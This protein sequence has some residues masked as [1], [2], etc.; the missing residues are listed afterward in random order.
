MIYNNGTVSVHKSY[1]DSLL[2]AATRSGLVEDGL[3]AKGMIYGI[4]IIYFTAYKFHYGDLENR[5]CTET[6]S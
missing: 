3:K 6:L 2:F 5:I 1:I 4:F